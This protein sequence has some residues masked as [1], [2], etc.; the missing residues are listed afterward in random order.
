VKV[1]CASM[2]GAGHAHPMASV[3]RALVRA[4][5][6]VV[7]ATGGAHAGDAAR[8]GA[9]FVELPQSRGSPRNALEPYADAEDMARIMS[10][11]VA[12]VAPDV[13]CIDLITLGPA[14]ACE[15]NGV[16]HAT[17]SIHPLHTPS[18][19]LPPFGWAYPPGRGLAR[20]RDDWL[21]RS[22]LKTLGRALADL[23]DARARLGLPRAGRID[24]QLSAHLILVATLPCLELPRSDWPAQAHVVGPCLWDAPGETPQLPPGDEPLV[25]IAATTAHDQ[26]AMVRASIEAV[27]RLGARA[28][29]TVGGADDSFE[30]TNPKVSVARFVSHDSVLPSCSAVVCSGGHGI[31]ARA[32]SHGVPTI[33]VPGPGDQR[34]NGYRV[35]RAGAGLRVMRPRARAVERALGRVLREPSFG[36]GAARA[37]EEAKLLDGPRRAVEL[38]EKLP[39]EAGIGSR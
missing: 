23:N 33:V 22:N 21:R 26:G 32:L 8:A 5:H 1:F 27:T 14:L 10:P 3:A 35:E 37:A 13:A 11:V 24:A 25:L 6:D 2:S 4:G 34:E 18:R 31:V 28:L 9:T 16:P 12:A 20:V 19:D 17:L 29:V 7:F 36:A 30:V 15:M 38:L 39:A